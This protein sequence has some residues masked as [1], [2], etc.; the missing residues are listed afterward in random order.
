MNN[1]IN[2]NRPKSYV[3]SSP[4]PTHYKLALDCHHEPIMSVEDI[5]GSYVEAR[6]NHNDMSRDHF[7][8]CPKCKNHELGSCDRTPLHRV[9]YMTPLYSKQVKE[10]QQ[11]EQLQV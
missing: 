6:D 5:K 2:N 9:V 8:I 7:I 11:Q 3:N 1:T 4:Q 10:E